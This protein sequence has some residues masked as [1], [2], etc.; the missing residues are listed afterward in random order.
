MRVTRKQMAVLSEMR[1]DDFHRRLGE[2]IRSSLPEGVRSHVVTD[3]QMLHAARR[4]TE[5]AAA[6]GI[7]R[8]ADVETFADCVVTL[9]LHF[10]RDARHPWAR[11]VLTRPTLT[12][13]EKA[14][15]L[16]DHLLF[17]VR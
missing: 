8:E 12:G 16:H 17:A 1:R 13:A 4:V 6:Y 10:D 7:R 9:G 2:R 3:E 14:S 11:G 5:A 15:L